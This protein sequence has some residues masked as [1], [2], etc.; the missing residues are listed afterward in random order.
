MLS[1]SFKKLNSSLLK[2]VL[3]RATAELSPSR[4]VYFRE[5]ALTRAAYP[6]DASK[7]RAITSSFSTLHSNSH[8]LAWSSIESAKK[9]DVIS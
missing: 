1:S 4:T 8:A 3:A 7:V 6:C 5:F 9:A 2:G